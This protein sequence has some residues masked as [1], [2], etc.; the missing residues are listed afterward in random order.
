M[1]RA[2]GSRSR[3]LG[4]ARGRAWVAIAADQKNVKQV[5]VKVLDKAF[6][7]PTFL[8]RSPVVRSPA[9][10]GGHPVPSTGRGPIRS[11]AVSGLL[12]FIHV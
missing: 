8:W 6:D 3:W 7:V 2:G 4:G 12:L 11:Q 5:S 9:D 1:R 10:A